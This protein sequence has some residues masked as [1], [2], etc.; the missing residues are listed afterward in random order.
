M[1]SGPRI[2]SDTPL[3]PKSDRCPWAIEQTGACLR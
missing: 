1:R 3:L 2:D